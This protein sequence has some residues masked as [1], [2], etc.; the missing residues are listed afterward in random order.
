MKVL[1]FESSETIRSI[2]CL[3]ARDNRI[4][5]HRSTET[6][7]CLYYTRSG[8]HPYL[9]RER[10]LRVA[11]WKSGVIVLVPKSVAIGGLI[12]CG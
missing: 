5:R 8:A 6:L 4:Q 10:D 2:L 11:S 3:D 1:G 9:P 12:A 7:Y